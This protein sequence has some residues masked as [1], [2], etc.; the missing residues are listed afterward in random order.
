MAS[1]DYVHGKMNIKEQSSTFDTFIRLS[2]WTGLIVGLGVFAL[3]LVYGA[4]FPWLGAA[5]GMIVL[6][7][8]LGALLKMGNA[9][10]YTLAGTGL[11]C[12]IAAVIEAVIKS[13]F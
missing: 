3:V 12:I 10:L 5:F 8:L 7:G 1:S 2:L 13:L 11:V 6:G 4:H 9:W